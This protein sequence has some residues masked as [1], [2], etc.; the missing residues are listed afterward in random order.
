LDQTRGLAYIKLFRNQISL[1]ELMVRTNLDCYNNHM[2]G[3]VNLNY[4]SQSE[5][6]ENPKNSRTA[7]APQGGPSISVVGDTY[8]III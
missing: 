3:L 7:V 4:N 2:A 6:M 8:R 5:K 1:T